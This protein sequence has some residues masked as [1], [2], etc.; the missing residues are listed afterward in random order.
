MIAYLFSTPS[1]IQLAA[2]LIG[3]VGFSLLFCV[4]A[5]YLWIDAVAGLLADAVYLIGLYA[6]SSELLSAFWATVFSSLLSELLARILK[7]P[8]PVF[9]LPAL[10]PIVPGGMLYHT[11]SA[12]FYRDFD[13][14][15]EYGNATL[16]TGVG[17]AAGIVTVSVLTGML[18][19]VEKSVRAKRKDP[20]ESEK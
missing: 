17:I 15:A 11:M 16:L 1:L 3:T 20:P 2:A 4:R 18:R 14:F 7:A 8:V 19:H 13:S 5:K 9:L 10:I 12:L 6:L